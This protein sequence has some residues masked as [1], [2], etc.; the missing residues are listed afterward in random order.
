M[1]DLP[2]KHKFVIAALMFAVVL[3]S[4]LQLSRDLQVV[5]WDRVFAELPGIEVE[6]ELAAARD[7][8]P[9]FKQTFIDDNYHR[10]QNKL[11]VTSISVRDGNVN[12][13]GQRIDLNSK[14]LDRKLRAFFVAG[15]KY[16][17]VNI[18]TYAAADVD[19]LVRIVSEA[20]N[21]Q[22]TP[23]LLPMNLTG[24]DDANDLV[25]IYNKI[26]QDVPNSL[27]VG[28]SVPKA[29]FDSFA[30]AR[31][32]EI[33]TNVASQLKE[34]QQ[35]A[36]GTPVM[37]ANDEVEKD[38]IE[39]LHE[40]GLDLSYFD[41]LLLDIQNINKQF[42]G[43]VGSPQYRSQYNKTAYY[44]FA[45]PV[46]DKHFRAKQWLTTN[47]NEVFRQH[48]QAIVLNFGLKRE[49]FSASD[50]GLSEL[51]LQ[52]LED[53]LGRFG[54]DPDVR[55]VVFESPESAPY[56]L[57]EAQISRL[58]L[59]LTNCNYDLEDSK[60]E[61]IQSA[62][63]PVC[64]SKQSATVAF[65]SPSYTESGV[66]CNKAAELCGGEIIYTVQIGLPIKQFGSN[67]PAGTDTNPYQPV[68]ATVANVNYF[69]YL[70]PMNQF[71]QRLEVTEG[72]E[73]PIPWL[74]SALYNSAE[75]L[76]VKF[77]SLS[78]PKLFSAIPIND[79]ASSGEYFGE[80]QSDYAWDRPSEHNFRTKTTWCFDGIRQGIFKQDD[81]LIINDALPSAKVI[82]PDEFALYKG[83]GFCVTK[84]MY[85]G[86]ADSLQDYD[87]ARYSTE[88]AS[89]LV[90]G[91][92][93]VKTDPQ[94]MIYG[95]E[96]IIKKEKWTG[97]PEELCY[98]TWRNENDLVGSPVCNLLREPKDPAKYPDLRCR[99]D[100]TETGRF[101]LY[102]EANIRTKT[103]NLNGEKIDQ[104]IQ[105]V[106]GAD[107]MSNTS[108]TLRKTS[109]PSD[110]E[111]YE[112]PGVY[113]A[114]AS[115]YRYVQ[116]QFGQRGL[117][118]VF[119]EDWGWQSDVVVR[120]Y[121]NAP[122]PDSKIPM[123][124][125]NLML[126]NP[127]RSYGSLAE[128]L[129]A[130]SSQPG[131]PENV[132]PPKVEEEEDEI[133][134]C[135]IGVNY[136]TFYYQLGGGEIS[137]AAEL[138]YGLG[139]AIIP[140]PSGDGEV[141]Q[142]KEKLNFMC[143]KGITPVIRSCVLG[144]CG[145][146]SGAQQAET[147]NR[148][149]DGLSCGEVFVT[150]GHNEPV[151]EYEP[152]M[153][154][155]GQFTRDCVA[156]IDTRGGRVKVTTPTFNATYGLGTGD[157][158]K[159]RNGDGVETVIDHAQDFLQGYGAG[160][161]VADKESK[162]SCLA[163]N[164]YDNV[165]GE[166]AEFYY[167]RIQEIP[168]FADMETCIMET[169]NLESNE[170][171]DMID[172][173]SRLSSMPG[174]GFLLGFN[175]MNTNPGWA[176]FAIEDKGKAVL[177][178]GCSGDAFLGNYFSKY[179][180]YLAKG[181]NWEL[182][183]QSYE[184]LG[185]LDELMRL[186]DV[187][188]KTSVLQSGEIN[189]ING[190]P[191]F[192]ESTAELFAGWVGCGSPAHKA[193]GEKTNCVG[194][195][196]DNDPLG[197]FL[198]QQGYIVDG[199]CQ[200]QCTLE[201]SESAKGGESSIKSIS[202][203]QPSLVDLTQRIE[204]V[205]CL[206]NGILIAMME[207]EITSAL[208]SLQ[209]D[210][211]KRLYPKKKESQVAWGPAMFTDIAWL[212]GTNPAHGKSTGN[213][214]NWEFGTKQCL[215]AIGIEY[216]RADLLEQDGAEY[217]LD[218]MVLGYA[219][220]GAASKLKMD[221][222]TGGK[223]TDWTQD[224]VFKAAE[225]YLG[226]CGDQGREY[227]S[228]YKQTMC[229]VYPGQNPTLCEG[230][231]T[232]QILECIPPVQDL[233]ADGQIRL[234][235]PLGAEGIN[236]PVSQKYGNNN[237][238]GVDYSAPLGT[239]VYA[240]AAGTV[241]RMENNWSAAIEG[242][243]GTAGN[244]V[245]IQHGGKRTFWTSYQHFTS[246]AP[247]IEVGTQV[248]AGQLIGFVGSTGRS[249]GP[250]LHFELRLRDCY[251]GYGEGKYKLGQCSTDPVPFILDA[252]G[253]TSCKPTS[254]VI[255]GDFACPIKDPNGTNISQASFSSG[256]RGSHA[257][258]EIKP[259]QPTD[260]GAAGG[261][262]VVAPTDSVVVEIRT[263]IDTIEKFSLN[264]GDGEALCDYIQLPDGPGNDFDPNNSNPSLRGINY[265][266]IEANNLVPINES[267][268]LYGKAG[269]VY[270]DAKIDDEG[271]AFY[272]GG[273][274]VHLQDAEGKLWRLV[275]LEDLKVSVGQ[276]VKKGDPIGVV[277]DGEMTGEWAPYS[278]R[279]NDGSG[280]WGVAHLHFAIIDAEGAK[281]PPTY[282]GNTIDS[283]PWVKQYC[284][285]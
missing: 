269:V 67:N 227:C 146:D 206:P 139:L 234:L 75:L 175:W 116:S 3:V 93:L 120:A 176:Q 249:S 42:D 18:Y 32:I 130:L 143:G 11:G 195:L 83:K 165:G 25:G 103:C 71:A 251:D 87:P 12:F 35:V 30:F 102:T 76:R 239:P 92:T 33:S 118:L 73:Y 133:N 22:L 224:E 127:T 90:C 250:H 5:R 216:P 284:G 155:E 66:V 270:Y 101:V 192:Q 274:V 183:N 203:L 91:D 186:S 41:F 23:I 180:Y 158:G 140:G 55:A 198:C 14:E 242:V 148:L 145:F 226:A 156:N 85:L 72:K 167:E 199:N 147:L 105:Y 107:S 173:V 88:F 223:C 181:K 159:D 135:R 163:F 131:A 187:L 164:T 111:N 51:S 149:T 260:I 279:G 20:T 65:N 129:G 27:F 123:G 252:A 13:N 97:S 237:H 273:F 60:F 36:V 174:F 161:F 168:E 98:S 182:H 45:Q 53:D 7:K 114:L 54:I 43:S 232:D 109:F 57:S 172:L 17:G 193:L 2:K 59:I 9:V 125:K 254:G 1:G 278:Q 132:E 194:I 214:F 208:P 64:E 80:L 63:A 213:G 26:S 38:F 40:Q 204:Q 81:E 121:M 113:A 277:Y 89:E 62:Q 178:A 74:G 150:C 272:D 170:T 52:R 264:G 48:M 283:T 153:V 128:S 259:Q 184:M 84:D 122:G 266:V 141:N 134:S 68:A 6:N 248:E 28:G 210:M 268:G 231:A 61:Y 262:E 126:D 29:Y 100:E 215:D 177:E 240:A 243:S 276:D 47:N 169:G 136:A 280:C 241:K 202:Q 110:I 238:S 257:E 15:G 200:N 94:N 108:V 24:G 185:Y 86:L 191:Q 144:G 162:I 70:N 256:G 171:G 152:G 79:F 190:V 207:R 95:S 154:A 188:A 247:D 205:S 69:S 222:G 142:I 253:I 230:L 137:E 104:C 211:Y 212:A 82:T 179:Q 217:V 16:L 267:Q 263:P 151:P 8:D 117:K 50:G 19:N 282:A 189:V 31:I 34:N 37:S 124:R 166:N 233:C 265:R 201:P 209:G 218:R 258:P 221:S 96:Q 99:C 245:V 228:V 160:Q 220:C 236:A 285:I 196:G 115:T 229:N 106:K 49:Y 46:K 244:F 138:G 44:Q 271:A 275:H 112:I 78:D 281:N 235:H 56:S 219:L 119:N 21:R 225:A 4:T 255:S 261:K 157:G 39:H 58:N 246:V 197:D 77:S 10:C